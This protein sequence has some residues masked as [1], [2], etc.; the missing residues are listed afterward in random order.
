VRRVKAT[1]SH[2]QALGVGLGFREPFRA[3]LF[4]NRERVDLLEITADHYFDASP[5]KES[6]LDLLAA[7][8]PLI[9]HGLNLSLGSAEGLD[10]AYLDRLASL[11]ERLNPPWW[12]EHVAFTRA[13]GVEIGHLASLPFSNEALDVVVRNINQVRERIETP[14]ILENITHS[15]TIPGAEMDEPSFL[16]RLTERTG[17]GL[18]LDVTNLYTNAMNNGDDP[19]ELLNRM[20]LDRVVQLHF[21]GGHWQHGRLIDSH[22]QPTP[23]EIWALMET[24]I[25]RAPVQ[26]IILERDE[27][28]PPFGDLLVEIERARAIGRR[29]QRW[30]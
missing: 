2:V 9:P 30:A 8:F 24:V 3:D 27:N 5:Q 11:V 6:E 29:Y 28:L 19:F 4:L 14:L 18:L 20:P 26:G 1:K 22:S 13:G 16:T 15:L 23:P 10:P 25:A 12:S 7:H 21:V 17:C